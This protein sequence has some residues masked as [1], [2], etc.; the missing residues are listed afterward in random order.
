MTEASKSFRAGD[1]LRV[2]VALLIPP[3]VAHAFRF[4]PNTEGYVLTFD[5]ALLAEQEGPEMGRALH[6]LFATPTTLTLPRPT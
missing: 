6:S 4:T 5:A 1:F 3:G 2:A